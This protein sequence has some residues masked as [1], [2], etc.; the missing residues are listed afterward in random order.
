MGSSQSVMSCAHA[1]WPWPSSIKKF[2]RS[3]RSAASILIVH[4]RFAADRP[5]NRQPPIVPD[6]AALMLRRIVISHLV[7]DD[8]VLR[9]DK[10]AVREARGHPKHVVLRRG[11][12]HRGPLAKRRRAA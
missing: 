7:L 9:Y 5:W 10:E 1:R 3:E 2:C 11:E 8:R 4:D 12:R 6:D